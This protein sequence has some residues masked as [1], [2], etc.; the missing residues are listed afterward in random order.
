MSEIPLERCDYCGRERR[1]EELEDHLALEDLPAGPE[2]H[3][4]AATLSP[5]DVESIRRQRCID[6]EDCQRAAAEG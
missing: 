1:P 4:D 3:Q 6:R 2:R 5:E